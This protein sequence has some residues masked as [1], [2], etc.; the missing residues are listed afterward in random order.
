MSLMQNMRHFCIHFSD[1]LYR[2]D[3]NVTNTFS[4][5]YNAIFFVRL[6]LRNRIWSK[7]FH[8]RLAGSA[9]FCSLFQVP[10][11]N[12][13]STI[14]QIYFSST[15]FSSCSMPSKVRKIKCIRNT[16]FFC[17]QISALNMALTRSPLSSIENQA[18]KTGKHTHVIL[19]F[20]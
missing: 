18:T 17:S 2:N 4:S 9:F 20:I 13:C 19:F 15:V 6:G 3:Q 7:S 1:D 5:I 10:L 16:R 14:I 8:W 12:L 11:Q